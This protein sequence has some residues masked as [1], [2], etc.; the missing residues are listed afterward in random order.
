MVLRT[1]GVKA[2]DKI[3]FNHRLQQITDDAAEK[4]TGIHIVNHLKIIAAGR[5]KQREIRTAKSQFILYGDKSFFIDKA[6]K[7]LRKLF[8]DVCSFSVAGIVYTSADD[9]QGVVQKVRVKFRLELCQFRFFLPK[10]IQIFVFN[11]GLQFGGHFVDG[12]GNASKFS[13]VCCFRQA[14]M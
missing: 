4:K 14:V 7:Q 6:T 5:M 10:L 1:A 2:V 9:F 12:T 11:Q 8:D 3:I 13:R